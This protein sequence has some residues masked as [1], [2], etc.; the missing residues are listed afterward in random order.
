VDFVRLGALSVK[1]AASGTLYWD[2][3][4]SRRASFIG[5]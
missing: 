5:P 1:T 2:E 4:E 3:F